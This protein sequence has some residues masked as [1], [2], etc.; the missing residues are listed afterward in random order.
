MLLKLKYPSCLYHS[1]QLRILPGRRDIQVST[2]TYSRCWCLSKQVVSRRCCPGWSTPHV[3]IIPLS[4]G[5]FL[6]GEISRYVHIHTFPSAKDPSWSEGYPGMYTFTHS[7]QPRILP[8]QR[9]IQV[10]THLHIHLSQGS[11]LVWEISRY[12][13]IHTFTSAND[14]SWSE[15]YP[16]KYPFTHVQY[17][18]I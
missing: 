14:P 2:N 1:P 9:D 13:H 15:R 17:M 6:V 3:C 12:V 8:G 5:S 7:P 18:L 4:Q 16:G 10:C 11:F